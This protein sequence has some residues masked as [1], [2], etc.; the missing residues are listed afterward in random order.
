MTTNFRSD[1]VIVKLKPT[2]SSSDI[3][4]LQAEIGVTNVST[5]EQ[6]NIDIW[7]VPAG[8]V[9]E[10]IS[11]YEDDPR[12]E[13]IEPDYIIT[14]ED[15]EKTSAPQE[16]LAEITP[17]TTTPNDPSYPQLWGLNNTGQSGGTP[18]A[19][20]DAPEA[21]DTQTGNPNQVIGVIDTGVD[22]NH[23]DLVGNIWTNPGEIA[24]DGIDND[25]NGYV[26]DV[27]GWDFAYNDNN[28]SDVDGHGTHVSGT[29][30]A[31]GNNGVGVVGVNW[32][33]K[34][35]PLKFLDDTGSGST[36]N[37]I[38]ALNYATAKGVKITNNSWGGGGYSQ[39]LYDAINTAGQQGALFIA[40]AGNEGRNTDLSPA[41]PASYNLPNIISVAATDRND[42]VPIFSNYGLTTVDL[43]APGVEIYST[44]PG[45]NYGYKTG[46]SMAS[47]HVTGG[48][49]LVWAQNPTWTAQEVKNRL[50]QTTDPI[51][52][53]SG[54][55]VSGGRL[56]VNNALG[57]S[58]P[59]PPP[60]PPP[61][62]P[63]D[64]FAQRIVLSGLPVSTT[65]TNIGAT[66]EPQE[67]AQSGPINS[68]WWSWTAPTSGTVNINTIGSS[69]DTWL[70]VYTGSALPNLT[71]IGADDDGG[72]GLTS[73]VSLNATAGTTYQIAVDGYQSNTGPIALNIVFPPPPNDNFANRIGL[74]GATATTTGTN[75]GAT[76][77]VGE[78]AQSGPINSSWWS[79]TAPTSGNYTF[80]TIGSGF[81]TYLSLFTG[82]AVS[83]LN[84]IGA[85]D[86][87]GGNYTSRLT[88]SVTAGTT[89]Q[90]A[91]DGFS[92]AT[93]PIQLN[94]SPPSPPN[95]N[96]ANQIALTGATATTT[97]TNN[98][99]TGEVGEPA[100]SGQIN[101]S[102]WSW[103]APTTG[104]YNI[105]TIGS[106]FDTYLSVFTG[107][108][109]SN[110]TLIGANDDGGG[111]LASLVSLN[112]TAG[113][114]YRIAV[115]GF[116]S[117]TGAVRL[118]IAPPPPPNDN[119]ANA[120]ALTGATATTT[121]R[122]TGATGQVG[123]PAQ[124]GQINSSWWSWTA[125]TTGQYN[126]D[127]IGSGF[128]TYLSVFTGS[129]LSSLTLIGANDDGGGNLASLVS[130]NATAGTTYRIA[131]DGY[132][133]AT[134]P[135]QLNIAPPAPPNDNFANQIALTG[136]TA[137]TTGTNNGATG[138][139][140]EPA[141][142]GPINSSWWSWTAPTTGQYN[143]STL[144][145]NFDTYLSVFTG[146]ALSSLTLIGANDD[147]GGGLTSLVSLNATAG[148]TYR[149]AVDGYSTATGAIQLN[150]APPP[151]ANDNF[152][153]RIALTGATATTTG[154]NRGATG[155]VGEP[156]QSG[157]INSSWWS[158]TAPTTGTYTIDTRGS[159]SD[160]YLSLFTG[161]TLPTLA[162][163]AADD[164]GGGL[165]TSLITRSFT[166]G[167]TYQIA[168]DGYSTVT[169][170]IRLSI[171]PGTT[172]SPYAAAEITETPNKAD[173][174][175]DPLTGNTVADTLSLPVT[176]L[177]I[178]QT[179]DLLTEG[180]AALEAPSLFS[181]AASDVPILVKD[182][183]PVLTDTN[184][185]LAGTASDVP[186][187][188][189]D[190][191]PV[192]TDT[193]G[194]LAGS[195][196]LAVN[197]EPLG[198]AKTSLFAEPYLVGT[199]PKQLGF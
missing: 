49:A 104:Q 108:P 156:A 142:S 184:G 130:L 33:A 27:R 2:V 120:I 21:W 91:V 87:G 46:T 29:I 195:Q 79:W 138:E 100:Q 12:V 109:V 6:F 51:P 189:K 20:I 196:P 25:N 122:N 19:D 88:R 92:T 113:T 28:P 68:V 160:T 66:A 194:V 129:A 69:F 105:D 132:S 133:S 83:S 176:D 67:P 153:N 86:D 43:G 146:S 41:Y 7:D 81:D 44:T 186:I 135:I 177:T 149:I 144:G 84:L 60:P 155:E 169:G 95:D 35:L 187:L 34:I 93:G 9:E 61:P 74:T 77:E 172:G 190:L 179:K 167:Q 1:R 193:N 114:T 76:G 115:D 75:N 154:T 38:L 182:L 64:N 157:P 22:Y 53:L 152:A 119:F 56:N 70:S 181:P 121:G 166:A 62:V 72:G 124:S 145:S 197:T 131:V 80:D 199:Q 11:A 55:T 30:A 141:Q 123:E 42:A 162:L 85:D 111:N 143:I 10:I 139:V 175:K 136:A 4:T 192:L 16:N 173:G 147:S 126:I 36:S 89:Y 174:G 26:D 185:V 159:G 161:S 101:S 23:P 3:N 183:N 116:G 31:K 134:G 150:I 171:T 103:T 102:W 48:A 45:A 140:G 65:G 17:Q 5:A 164:D 97:G 82:S 151:P 148:T 137:T 127:T 117:A 98:G 50:L 180:G 165:L 158:W 15:V 112:A 96:F 39:G 99:A 163:V 168:V 63:N 13:Y 188:V 118:N 78:P 14:L 170:P 58:T 191:N 18:D 57:G 73:L 106:G 128:D 24:G 90:I 94:I 37:A 110:L 198:V 54:R 32:N 40:A 52:A 107:S 59:P 47:P 178:G 125:P 8:N 71:L